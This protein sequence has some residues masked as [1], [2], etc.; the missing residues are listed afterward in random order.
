MA[1]DYFITCVVVASKSKLKEKKNK[2][3]KEHTCA[4]QSYKSKKFAFQ[5]K[6]KYFFVK[7]TIYRI[8]TGK[9]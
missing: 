2:Q 1:S 8:E 7:K 3:T 4:N 9:F 6:G 5:A